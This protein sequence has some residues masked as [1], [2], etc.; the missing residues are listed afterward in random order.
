MINTIFNEYL[1]NMLILATTLIYSRYP[2][3]IKIDLRK[4]IVKVICSYKSLGLIGRNNGSS[5][6]EKINLFIFL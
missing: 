1:S 5:L 4:E 6:E 3:K 2:L